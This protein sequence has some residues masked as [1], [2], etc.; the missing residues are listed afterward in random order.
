MLALA[1]ERDGGKAVLWT[2]L[3]GDGRI[4]VCGLGSLFTDNALGLADTPSFWPIL[5]A[6]TSVAPAPSYL[7]II[8]RG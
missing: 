5:S 4:I 1:H 7:M 3:A 6:R 8:I 2:R